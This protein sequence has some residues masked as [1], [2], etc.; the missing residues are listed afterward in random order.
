MIRIFDAEKSVGSSDL[1]VSPA[2]ATA[3]LLSLLVVIDAAD[4]ADAVLEGEAP[5][6]AAVG[7]NAVLGH[8][9]V[10]RG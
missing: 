9:H 10:L 6:T 1:A 8:S 2:A 5:L 3:T 7:A 4:E